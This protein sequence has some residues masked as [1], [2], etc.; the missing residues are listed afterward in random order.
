MTGNVVGG[1][2]IAAAG[3]AASAAITVSVA[4]AAPEAV[5]DA[6]FASVIVALAALFTGRRVARPEPEQRQP[7]EPSERTIYQDPTQRRIDQ[8]LAM[9]REG[10]ITAKDGE[11]LIDNLRT[12]P[13]ERQVPAPP[14]GTPEGRA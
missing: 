11:R 14:Y 3:C 8:T 10:R 7:S 1:V 4:V 9:I 5:S 2:V 13:A 12:H 6:T